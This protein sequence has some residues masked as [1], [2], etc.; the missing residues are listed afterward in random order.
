VITTGSGND[1]ID[2]G[3]GNDT[4]RPGSGTNKVKNCETVT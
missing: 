4:C 2:G 3:A 1:T